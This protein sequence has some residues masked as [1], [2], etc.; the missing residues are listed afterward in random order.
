MSAALFDK[1]TAMMVI[2]GL[3]H[4]PTLLHDQESVRL[5]LD[6]FA[7]DF[8]QIVFGSIYNLVME[9]GL[10]SLTPVDIDFSIARHSRQ[11]KI[12]QDNNGMKFLQEVNQLSKDFDHSKFMM[13]YERLKK[14]TLLRDLES[15]GISTKSFYNPNVSVER[16]SEQERK[17][18]EATPDEILREVWGKLNKVEE[19][20]VSRNYASSQTAAKGIRDLYFELKA[21][22]EIGPPLQGEIFNY[23]VRGARPGK[24]YMNSAPTGHGKT[25]MMLGNAASLSVPYLNEAGDVVKRE[26]LHKV[27]FVTTEQ[28]AD[29][30]QTLLLAFVSGVNEKKILYGTATKEEEKRIKDA[31]DIIE[32]YEDYFIIEA[33]PDPSIALVRAK[34]TKHIIQ[35]NVNFIFYDYIFSSP[36]LITE[37]SAAR[38]REDVALM[39]LSNTIKEVGSTFNVFIE[40]ST[41]LNERWE[42]SKIRNQNHIRGSK[43]IADKIDVGAVSVKLNALEEEE[44][45]IRLIAEEAS[46]RMPNMVM[47]IYKNRRGEG[48]GLKLYRYFDHGTCRATDIMLTDQQLRIV[49]DYNALKYN[50]ETVGLIDILTGGLE[51]E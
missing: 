25:R 5:T 13:H 40:S 20:Y 48:A 15:N 14:L 34:L 11:S 10:E 35:N 24:V 33:I 31:I 12:F 18:N 45:A 41:Q 42:N 37:F 43:A 7:N 3:F 38:I 50:V 21:N 51:D 32:H 28:Q 6:D 47:D 17:L 2:A 39:M 4:D 23:L 16:R 46:L 22:P 8:Y 49:K 19:K 27:L 26:D 1:N 29:E 9:G 36:G 30:I 44:E